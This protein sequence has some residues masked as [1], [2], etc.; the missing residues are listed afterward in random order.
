[1]YS[2]M[3][4]VGLLRRLPFGNLRIKGRLSLPEADCY[5]LH[6]LVARH[7]PFAFAFDRKNVGFYIKSRDTL[8]IL[9]YKSIYK[10]V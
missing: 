4:D 6:A 3:S 2:D 9:C 7:P 8:E 5:V 10:F 1:M